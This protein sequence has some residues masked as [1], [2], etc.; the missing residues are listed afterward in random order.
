[1]NT[2]AIG[3]DEKTAHDLAQLA[4]AR[5]VEPATL[6][7]EAIRAYFRTEAQRAMEQEAEAFCRLHPDLLA[8]ISGEYAA[9]YGGQLIDH[10]ADQLTLFGRIEARFPGLP[11]LIRQVRPEVEQ[12]IMVRSPRIEVA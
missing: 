10:D 11:V 3:L 4:R 12:T 6:A 8:T 5:A 9:I 7:G 1:M 2:V